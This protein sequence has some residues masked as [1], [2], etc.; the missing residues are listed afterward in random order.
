MVEAVWECCHA[1]RGAVEV[2]S[3]DDPAQQHCGVPREGPMGGPA[4]RELR[5]LRRCGHA[6]CSPNLPDSHSGPP[7]GPLPPRAAPEPG[8]FGLWARLPASRWAQR[9]CIHLVDAP[10]LP[11]P[12]LSH[13][14]QVRQL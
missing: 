9:T 11:L 7:A 10:F 13:G 4:R 6:G 14:A 1:C 3:G 8:S 12:R 2:R 5:W